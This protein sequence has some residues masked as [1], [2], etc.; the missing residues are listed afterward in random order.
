MSWAALAISEWERVG[1]IGMIFRSG[2]CFWMAVW[3]S[4]IWTFASKS[5]SRAEGKTSAKKRRSASENELAKSWRRAL[6]L[7]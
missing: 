6:V 7:V 1:P 3:S 4:E 2:D 5:C